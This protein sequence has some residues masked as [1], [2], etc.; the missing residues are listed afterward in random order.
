[1]VRRKKYEPRS[2]GSGRDSGPRR[3]NPQV[4]ARGR[5]EY[6]TGRLIDELTNVEKREIMTLKIGELTS[7][8]AVRRRIGDLER[9]RNRTVLENDELKIL[10]VLKSEAYRTIKM[11]EEMYPVSEN[12]SGHGNQ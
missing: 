12:R 9:N 1:M 10:N 8:N 7:K 5:L 2:G 11:I 4:S 6:L 3:S